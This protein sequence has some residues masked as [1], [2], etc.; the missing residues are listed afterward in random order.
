MRGES[1]AV[2]NFSENLSVLDVQ[3]IPKRGHNF[4][5]LFHPFLLQCYF[6]HNVGRIA[7]Y[8]KHTVFDIIHFTAIFAF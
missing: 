4:M 7:L 3:G 1:K 6:E 5:N 8:F 2:W